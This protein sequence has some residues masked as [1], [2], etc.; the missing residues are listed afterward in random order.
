MLGAQIMQ[1][2]FISTPS[3]YT[4]GL[5]QQS[6]STDE[7]LNLR[8]FHLFLWI[9]VLVEHL[10][11]WVEPV[12]AVHKINMWSDPRRRLFL[13][14]EKLKRILLLGKCPFHGGPK[15]R[16]MF[17]AHGP[18]ATWDIMV[19]WLAP[20]WSDNWIFENII[21]YSWKYWR[22]LNL[23]VEPKIAFARILAD[24]NLA[25]R[26]GIAIRIYASRKF[27]RILIWRLQI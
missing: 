22:E 1:P 23:A 15:S 12:V 14:A 8:E 2:G 5:E 16:V 19:K 7:G 25:V 10:E 26:Y 27:W 4:M 17:N 11:H 3:V 24:L 20:H 13:S 9:S 18:L 21:P 6:F